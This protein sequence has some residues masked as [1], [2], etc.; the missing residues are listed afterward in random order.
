MP[1]NNT[2]M[3]KYIHTY[4]DKQTYIHAYIHIYIDT[5]THIYKQFLKPKGTVVINATFS[6]DEVEERIPPLMKKQIAERDGKLFLINGPKVG[7]ET[8]MGKRINMVMQSVFFKLSGVMPFTEAIALLKKDI[9]KMYGKKGDKVCICMYPGVCAVLCVCVRARACVTLKMKP[10]DAHVVNQNMCVVKMV[11]D[12]LGSQLISRHSK[13][14]VV[15]TYTHTY[16][17]TD[18]N[19]HVCTARRMVRVNIYVYMYTY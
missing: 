15:S 10:K 19:I 13:M 5:H 9:A 6:A 4:I 16:I 11:L 14:D 7:Q 3:H 12:N 1:H 18:T 8:G 17:H 2:C